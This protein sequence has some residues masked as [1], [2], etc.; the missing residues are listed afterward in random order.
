MKAVKSSFITGAL[1]SASAV[2]SGCTT[3]ETSVADGQ[4]LKTILAAQINDVEATTRHGT[5]APRGTDPE[6]SNTSVNSVRERSKGSASRPGLMESL[7]G[8]MGRN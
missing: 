4:S 3:T 5:T 1:V 6:V 7:F 8:G 2:L